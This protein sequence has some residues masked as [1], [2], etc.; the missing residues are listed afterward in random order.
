MM[1][2]CLHPEG[3]LAKCLH[4]KGAPTDAEKEKADAQREEAFKLLSQWSR[5]ATD[6][7]KRQAR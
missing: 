1:M 5:T 3:E 6:R 7:A 2:K 4:P